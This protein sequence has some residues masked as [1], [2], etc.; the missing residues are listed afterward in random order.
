MRRVGVEERRVFAV[1]GAKGLSSIPYFRRISA[2]EVALF[3]RGGLSVSHAI[4]DDD[5][6]SGVLAEGRAVIARG[7]P[8]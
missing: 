4:A 2:V 7:V 5:P 6:S 3:G 1:F 8:L